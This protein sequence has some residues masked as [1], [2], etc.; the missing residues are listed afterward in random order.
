MSTP[1]W[2]RD[3]GCC[4]T[5]WWP[6]SPT[7]SSSWWCL[8]HCCGMCPCRE[9]TGAVTFGPSSLV[10]LL[11]CHLLPDFTHPIS[12]HSSL[13]NKCTYFFV[14]TL[15]TAL[16]VRRQALCTAAAVLMSSLP[17]P[18]G[19]LTNVKKVEHLSGPFFWL[20]YLYCV[21]C[22]LSWCMCV[23]LYSYWRASPLISS[24][25]LHV[26]VGWACSQTL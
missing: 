11:T 12:S 3:I 10:S 25:S 24:C 7:Q 20:I 5:R 18:W 6:G 15:R 1:S 13:C 17:V 26:H 21:S 8:W 2:T 14:C 23:C 16:L 22:C 9:A 19:I 4:E